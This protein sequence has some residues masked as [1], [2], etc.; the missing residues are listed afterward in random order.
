MT[1]DAV[2]T[3]VSLFEPTPSRPVLVSG[4]PGN[5]YVG[6]L[7]AEHL[8]SVFRAKKFREYYSPTFP[9]QANVDEEGRVH[10]LRGELYLARTA[11]ANDLLI[12]TADAQP[13]TSEGEYELSDMVLKEAKRL[14]AEMVVSLAAFITGGFTEGG[15]VYGASTSAELRASLRENGVKMMKEG[16][17]TGMNG[18][19]VGMAKLEG[20]DGVC[21]L[22]ETSGYLV[23]PAASQAVIEAMSRLLKMEIDVSTLKERAA[24]AKRLIGQIRDMKEPGQAE[25]AQGPRNQPGY[26]G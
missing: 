15:G 20:M 21:L 26:I 18:L 5:G 25:G 6:K 11:Q 7:S 14:G 8:I 24:E 13:A 9:P 12:F 4:L 1:D 19:M 23:D 16:T 2:V 17:V 10:A 3:V 22:G